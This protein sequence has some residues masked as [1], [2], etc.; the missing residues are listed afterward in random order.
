MGATRRLHNITQA[1][2]RGHELTQGVA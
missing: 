1:L 2:Q